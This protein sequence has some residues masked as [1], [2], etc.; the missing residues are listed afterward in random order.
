MSRPPRLISTLRT[1]QFSSIFPYKDALSSDLYSNSA[2]RLLLFFGLFPLAVSLLGQAQL[3]QTAWILGIYYASIWALVLRGLISP[4]QFSWADVVKFMGFTAFVGIP[5]LLLAQKL[6]PFSLLYGAVDRLRFLPKLLGFVLGVGLLEESCKTL[7]IYLFLLRSRRA[8]DPHT[9]AFY[10]AMSGLGFA[11]AEG[12]YYSLAYARGLSA[13][14]LSSTSFSSYL[15]ANTV[16]FVTLPLVH[17]IWA[18]IA[19]YFV[20]LAALNPSRQGVLLGVGIAIAAVLHGLYNTLAGTILGL[21]VLAFS[22]LLFMAYL[23]RSR[24]LMAELR[25]AEMSHPLQ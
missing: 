12:A 5:L 3:Q 22:M 4:P 11:I 14:G 8:D 24:A 7:P 20:G 15:V 1:L 16:R 9:F 25:A 2:V 13:Y 17:G 10:G 21:A 18:G 19:G 23:R 6:P